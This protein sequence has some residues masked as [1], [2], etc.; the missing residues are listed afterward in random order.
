[1]GLIMKKDDSEDN[2][3]IDGIEVVGRGEGPNGDDEVEHVEIHEGLTDRGR[4][5]RRGPERR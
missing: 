4:R 1:M 3:Y 2:E 5:P